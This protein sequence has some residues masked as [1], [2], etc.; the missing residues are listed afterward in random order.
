MV[1]GSRLLQRTTLVDPDRTLR[2][3]RSDAKPPSYSE[4]WLH[5]GLFLTR[6][7]AAAEGVG[8]NPSCSSIISWSNIRLNETCLPSRKRSTWM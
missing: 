6:V 1:S 5:D 4:R 3:V 8:R 7:Y 2:D